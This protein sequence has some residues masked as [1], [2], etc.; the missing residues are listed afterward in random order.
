MKDY[1]ITE[2]NKINCA[3]SDRQADQFL[4]YF[5]LLT[6][7]NA[8][9]NL[10]AITEFKEVVEKHFIDSALL[11]EYIKENNPKSLIDIG[12]GAGFPGVP[13][14]ILFPE[15]KVTLLDSL[16]KRIRFLNTVIQELGLE[17]IEAIHGRAEEYGIKEVYREQYDLCVSRAVARLASLCEFCIPFVKKGGAF[18][19]YKAV[20]CNVPLNVPLI[21]AY[22]DSNDSILP[23]F[24]ITCGIVAIE[25]VLMCGDDI[26][27]SPANSIVIPPFLDL[28]AKPSSAS[29][30]A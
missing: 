19:A 7:W 24:A 10:T 3:I 2:F 16:N 9:M 4:R 29:I 23:I 28:K 27:K 14:K 8:V 18:V 22:S 12:T 13:L 21:C 25:S 6:E 30:S 26:F 1:I 20:P 5:E 11:S 17:N 15:M